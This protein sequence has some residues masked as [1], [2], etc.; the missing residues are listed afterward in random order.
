MQCLIYYKWHSIYHFF[1]TGVYISRGNGNNSDIL[2]SEI[3]VG[4][5]GA[6]LCY[7]DLTQCCR[8]EHSSS[9]MAVGEWFYPNGSEVT[10]SASGDDFYRNRGPSLVR[11]NRRNNATSPEGQYCCVVP[12]ATFT[13]VTVCANLC[14]LF[15]GHS[16]KI[17]DL[18]CFPYIWSKC[19]D[20]VCGLHLYSL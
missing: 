15:K 4:D 9:G 11:L 12:D 6:L 5:D 18:W 20:Y 13:N 8:D 10:I 1:F 19:H 3:G 7:T 17:N 2:I 16:S 14:K